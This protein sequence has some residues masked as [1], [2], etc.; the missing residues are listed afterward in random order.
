MSSN[1]W[2]HDPGGES[3]LWPGSSPPL[4]SLEVGGGGG[5]HHNEDLYL[6]NVSERRTRCHQAVS[7]RWLFQMAANGTSERSNGSRFETTRDNPRDGCSHTEHK[8][9]WGGDGQ[10]R[11]LEDA[12]RG[13][14]I[15]PNN[16]QSNTS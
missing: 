4:L 15:A 13:F 3:Q 16:S 8:A 5:G 1:S 7:A 6:I 11:S 12:A 10:Q 14:G 9:R 2:Q